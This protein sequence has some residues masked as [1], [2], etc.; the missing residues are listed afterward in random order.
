MRSIKPY[1]TTHMRRAMKYR[2]AFAELISL[3]YDSCLR[4]VKTIA[5]SKLR[6][7]A[8]SDFS[9]GTSGLSGRGFDLV[10]AARKFALTRSVSTHGS[11]PPTV[12]IIDWRR[13]VPRVYRSGSKATN[14]ID[15]AA[16]TRVLGSTRK[17]SNACRAPR[18]NTKAIHRTRFSARRTVEITGDGRTTCKQTRKRTTRPPVHFMVLHFVCRSR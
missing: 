14:R 5:S 15:T 17:G 16:R 10:D 6:L 13:T 3:R 11:S 8:R 4:R 7:F 2:K 18:S 12:N 9:R 1:G